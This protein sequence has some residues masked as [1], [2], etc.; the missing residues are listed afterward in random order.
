MVCETVR[1]AI[2]KIAKDHIGIPITYMD[3]IGKPRS[4]NNYTT[5]ELLSEGEVIRVIVMTT[6]NFYEALK[7]AAE[8]T[9]PGIIGT[10]LN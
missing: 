10:P 9:M 7:L 3:G 4:D 8:E 1:V 2:A 5:L 6:E